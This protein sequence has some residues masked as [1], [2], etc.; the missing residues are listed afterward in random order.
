M[1]QESELSDE[2]EMLAEAIAEAPEQWVDPD[3]Q[4]IHVQE[5]AITAPAT[6]CR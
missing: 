1:M 5:L 3:E 4:T 6:R 2:Q